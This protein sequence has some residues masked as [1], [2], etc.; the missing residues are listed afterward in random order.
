MATILPE[1]SEAQLNGIT[2]KAEAKLYRSLR[3]NLDQSY[4]VLFQVGWILKHEKDR[5]RDGECDFVIC[6][7][8]FGYLCI[9]VK[10]GGI[11]YEAETDTWYSIDRNNT[12]FTIKDPVQQALRAKFSIFSKLREHPSWRTYNLNNALR[13]HAVFFPDIGS[14]T[15]LSRPN[16]PTILIGTKS[17][18]SDPNE[19]VHQ[20]FYYWNSTSNK[21]DPIGQSGIDFFKKVFARSFSVP[22]LISAQLEEIEQR[23]IELTN[24]Q[25]SVLDL[26][27]SHRRVAIRGGAGTGKTV[28]AMEKARR[29]ANEGFKTLLTCYNRQLADHLS[30]LCKGISNLEVM[31]FH[32]LCYQRVEKAN[33]VSG[34]DL[35]AEAKITYPGANVFEVQLPNAL[36]YSLEVLPERYDAIVCDEGQDFREEFWVPLELLLTDLDNSP[37]YV[38]F[39]DNQNIY[40]RAGTFPIQDEAF[41]LTTNC[42]NTIPIHE[43]AYKGY[44]GSPVTPPENDGEEIQFICAQNTRQQAV[45]INSSIVDLIT[46]QGVSPND[47]VVLIGDA[48]HKSEYYA[49]L[50]A[51]P[52]PKGS[53]WLE[54]GKRYESNVLIDT[55]HRFKGLESPIVF[56]WGLDNL[57]LTKNKELLYVGI[58]RAKSLLVVC[59]NSEVQEHFTKDSH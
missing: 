18:L 56:L 33:R 19:W 59:G 39:D 11:S 38:F 21:S 1:L 44:Q 17:D 55:I 29:L 35:L 52:L 42:R 16:L 23:R 30:I 5:A 32:Q 25:I 53:L 57:N 2:S 41:P 50:K 6:H 3:D 58:S 47:I 34:R 54:E 46:Q 13:G 15:P 27:Q 31:N 26:L 10:G 51:L 9:E 40:A 45:K 28:L 14:P 37:L 24:Q 12:K 8:K 43:A 48:Y 20:A 49:E 4:T 36:G 22:P 7:P